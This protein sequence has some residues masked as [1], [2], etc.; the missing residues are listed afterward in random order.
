MTEWTV[1]LKIAVSIKSVIYSFCASRCASAGDHVL[2]RLHVSSGQLLCV[3][4]VLPGLCVAGV[5]GQCFSAVC[6]LIKMIYIS[7]INPSVSKHEA[8]SLTLCPPA[9]PREPWGTS[10]L[11]AQSLRSGSG[12]R[13]GKQT[14]PR[15]SKSQND[16]GESRNMSFTEQNNLMFIFIKLTWHV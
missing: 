8:Y 15:H 12:G 10:H 9:V 5:G 11:A 7:H 6:L 13:R 14:Q 2:F 1:P 4:D 16:H 3:H